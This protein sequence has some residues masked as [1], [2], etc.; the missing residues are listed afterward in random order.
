MSG[1]ST[2]STSWPLPTATPVWFM[3]SSRSAAHAR[4]QT[5]VAL[6]SRT[7]NHANAASAIT[8]VIAHSH[9]AGS[10]G[11]HPRSGHSVTY[12][13]GGYGGARLCP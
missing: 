3:A 1:G 12:V 13:A 4:S 7:I 10:N 6:L 11:S 2:C 5:S 9:R 8:V